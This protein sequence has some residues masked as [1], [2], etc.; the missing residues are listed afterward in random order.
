[1]QMALYPMYGLPVKQLSYKRKYNPEQYNP[2]VSEKI[3]RRCFRPKYEA[4]RFM[5]EM[6]KAKN[7]TSEK[8]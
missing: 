2:Q 7:M 5:E 3:D 8:K 1:M 6:L 4:K